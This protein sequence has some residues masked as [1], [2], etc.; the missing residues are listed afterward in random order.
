MKDKIMNIITI[1]MLVLLIW[2]ALSYIEV[3][4]KNLSAN[5]QYCELNLF[6]MLGLM[7]GL[8]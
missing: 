7:R 3:L 8:D 1:L 4:S 5:P 2:G 6:R